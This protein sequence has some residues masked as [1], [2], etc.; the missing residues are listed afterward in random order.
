MENNIQQII[1]LPMKVVK[2]LKKNGVIQLVKH[3]FVGGIIYMHY[4]P[5]LRLA[6]KSRACEGAGQE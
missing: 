4:N 1:V 3:V 2:R 6:T 5:S